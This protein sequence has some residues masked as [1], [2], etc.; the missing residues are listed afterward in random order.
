MEGVGEVILLVLGIAAALI[1][2]TIVG[3]SV[4]Y[5]RH[6]WRNE[7]GY[8]AYVNRIWRAQDGYRR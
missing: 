3:Y 7:V 4:W 2:V 8:R 6:D 1:L 5:L